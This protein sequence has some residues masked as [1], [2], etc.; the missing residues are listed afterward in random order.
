MGIT[1]D[2]FQGAKNA[3]WCGEYRMGEHNSITATVNIR[4]IKDMYPVVRFMNALN[5]VNELK[6]K[7]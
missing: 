6:A 5:R 1:L 7:P 4:K 3:K 2:D